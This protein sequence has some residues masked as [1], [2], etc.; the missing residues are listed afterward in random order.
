MWPQLIPF[1]LARKSLDS[2]REKL[3]VKRACE[4]KGRV[5]F[6]KT[7]VHRAT[8]DP[9]SALAI[10]FNNGKLSSW[11]VGG[12]LFGVWICHH[13]YELNRVRHLRQIKGHGRWSL[14]GCRLVAVDAC[15]SASS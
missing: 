6:L 3:R 9:E 8:A 15:I 14:S 12:Y 1:S 7:L 2:E 10:L 11:A 4:S 5:S 13:N